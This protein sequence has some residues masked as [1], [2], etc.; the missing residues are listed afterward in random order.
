MC[1]N[2]ATFKLRNEFSEI[3]NSDTIHDLGYTIKLLKEDDI[4][5]WDI[6]LLGAP[7]S[8]YADG[9]FHIRLS[10]PKDYPNKSPNICF[11]TPIYHLNV[12]PR[13]SN[14]ERAGP[15]GFVSVS[16]IN[17]WKPST[18]VKEILIKLYSIFD[19]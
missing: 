16:F 8:S 15:L 17:W 3:T 10:F 14:Y 7:D 19:W 1:L 4:S 13:I 18:T 9:I 11:L 12:N 5:E 2:S 6:T